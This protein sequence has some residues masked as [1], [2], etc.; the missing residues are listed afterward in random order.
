MLHFLLCRRTRRLLYLSSVSLFSLLPPFCCLTHLVSS[1]PSSQHCYSHLVCFLFP[2]VL[3]HLSMMHLMWTQELWD[4]LLLCAAGEILTRLWC[5]LIVPLSNWDALWSP[6]PW[7]QWQPSPWW[8]P[9]THRN[10]RGRERE[11]WVG[12]SWGRWRVG[13]EKSKVE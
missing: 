5:L 7:R 4:R 13:G 3:H 8:Q 6:S 11:R 1:S 12:E 2:F 9:L 10:T